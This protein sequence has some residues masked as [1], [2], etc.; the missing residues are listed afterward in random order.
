VF[1]IGDEEVADGD[2]ALLGDGVEVLHGGCDVEG[3]DGF[4]EEIAAVAAAQ[5]VEVLLLVV[6]PL[7]HQHRPV[8][9]P[10]E[11]HSQLGHHQH[12]RGLHLQFGHQAALA[13]VDGG[14]GEH[15]DGLLLHHDG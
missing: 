6:R 9:R 1:G 8:V 5:V 3:D 13:V 11:Q 14:P 15:Q 4:V 7:H 2:G 10:D 12:A